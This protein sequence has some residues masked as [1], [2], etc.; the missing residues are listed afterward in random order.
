[1]IYAILPDLDSRR[2]VEHFVDCFYERLLAD[3]VLAP[4]FLQVAAIDLQVHLPHIK[5]YWCKLLLGDVTYRRHTMAIHRRLHARQPLTA[6]D[7]ECWLSCFCLT[8]DEHFAGPQAERAKRLARAIAGNMRKTLPA[9]D[10]PAG[11]QLLPDVGDT[12]DPGGND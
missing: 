1:M 6:G 2:H 5:D 7:F 12:T 8:I 3:P 11:D 4:L 9:P 10:S